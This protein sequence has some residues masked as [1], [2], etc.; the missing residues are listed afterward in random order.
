MSHEPLAQDGSTVQAHLSIALADGTVVE[1]TRDDAQPLKTRLGT[2]DVHPCI[3][4]ALTGLAV[5]E[6]RRVELAPGEAF[7]EHDGSATQTMARSTFPDDMALDVG[8]VVA[9]ESAMGQ[10]V[11]G[12]VVELDNERVEVDFNHPLAGRSVILEVE[13]L[14]LDTPPDTAD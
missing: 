4:Q 1:N 3:E 10:P 14:A 13:L 5:G 2:A 6:R 9:F 8:L 7:G 11:A 12:T